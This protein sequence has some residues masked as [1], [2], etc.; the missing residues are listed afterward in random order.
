MNTEANKQIAHLIPEPPV[1]RHRFPLAKIITTAFAAIV[2]L[3]MASMALSYYRIISFQSLL[4]HI[5][6]D[7]FPEMAYSRELNKQVNE[8]LYLSNHLSHAGN[9]VTLRIAKQRIES[10]LE[11]IKKQMHPEDPNIYLGTQLRVI[12]IEFQTLANLV[13]QQLEIQE[14]IKLNQSSMYQLNEEMFN[15]PLQ[16]IKSISEKEL[17]TAW[18]LAYSKVI[19]SASKALLKNRLQA[20]RQSLLKI[21]KQLAI[22]TEKIVLLPKS[23]QQTSQELVAK[24]Q[25]LLLQD[26][27]MLLLKIEQLRIDGRV[28][29]RDNFM[30]N[31]LDD[32]LRVAEFKSYQI[33]S[34][35]IKDTNAIIERV[36]TQEKMIAFTSV[37]VLLLL[38]AVIYFIEK[39]FV[40]RIVRLNKNVMSRLKGGDAVSDVEG[41]DEISDLSK[42][43]NFFADKIEQQKQ[44]LH[45]LSLTDGLTGLANR[46]ALDQR[47]EHDLQTAI[48]KRWP[49]AV[50]LMDIDFFKKYN[51]IYGHLAGD[52][53]LKQVSAALRDC[54]KR[55]TDFI[56]RY[57]GEEFLIILPDTQ[58][59][60][61][62]HIANNILT[63][64]NAL[65]LLHEGS[66]VASHVTLSIGIAVFEP[67]DAIDS[68][69]L[70]AKADKALYSAKHS[71]KNNS[72]YYQ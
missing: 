14:K 36:A 1:E 66:D 42:A 19:S 61:A 62:Q 17:V 70:I 55:S 45:D 63:E 41:S 49:V 50:L 59:I 71:G 7:S 27:G 48:R 10:K 24:L 33:N 20:V 58:G 25:Q 2:I 23:E 32:F 52:E 44:V 40:Q 54:N 29:G 5:K 67:T 37:F 65:N 21:K 34:S 69:Q 8:L 11:N 3:F 47:L 60:S 15:L 30:K 46:R 43:F 4:Y 68:K 72:Y 16:N 64:I 51:D 57:G 13:E 39:R 26:D 22:L 12:I 53:C 31:L 28:I 38:C 56:A 18:R 9:E 35:V 6:E